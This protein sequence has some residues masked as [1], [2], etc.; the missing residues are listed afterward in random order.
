MPATCESLPA[1][2]PDEPD[3]HST[4]RIFQ[5]ESGRWHASSRDG[6]M[7]GVFFKRDAAIRFAEDESDGHSPLVLI[8]EPQRE[9]PML[10]PKAA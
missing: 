10:P 3:P 7:L 8:L 4:F 1:S 9:R 2:E 5:D 6:M